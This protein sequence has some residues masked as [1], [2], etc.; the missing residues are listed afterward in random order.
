[1]LASCYANRKGGVSGSIDLERALGVHVGDT[2]I[3]NGG[4]RLA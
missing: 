2:G 1:M 3:C 4:R